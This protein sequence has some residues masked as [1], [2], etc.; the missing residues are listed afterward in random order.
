MEPDSQYYEVITRFL[1]NEASPEE[2]Q[3]VMEWMAT[4]EK[5]RLYV[6]ELKKALHLVSLAQDVANVDLDKEWKRLH[7][8]L[9]KEQS[10]VFQINH[11][12][13]ADDDYDSDEKQ[14]GRTRIFKFLI[15]VAV[16]ASLIFMIGLGAGWFSS[17]IIPVNE[18]AQQKKPEEV[19]AKIDPLMTVVQHEVNTSGK[20]KQLILPDGTKI[21][22]YNNSELT[23]KEPVA[24]KRRD[25][26]LLGKADFSVARN[27]TKPFTVFSED[28]STTA[29]GTVFTVDVSKTEKF[30]RIKLAEGKVVV[31]SLKGY[32]DK[33]TGNHYLVPGQELVYDKK[34][35][36]IVVNSFVLAKQ[37]RNKVVAQLK[38]NPSIPHYDKRSWFMFNNQALSEIFD[39][40]AEMYDVKIVY[41][42]KDVKDMYFIGTYDKSD[43]LHKILNQIALLNNLG[44]TRQNDTF[45]IKKQIP[46]K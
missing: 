16:A 42:K 40:L 22:L 2:E 23:Y 27:K 28:I 7:K 18:T 17:N 15:G 9:F 39:A 5:N 4:E 20:T 35:K 19:E 30:I 36:A 46:K 34:S 41:D 29:I 37:V 3:F 44:V 10:R 38:E 45:K 43:S 12:T 13:V 24:G 11:N 31:R 25:V 26:Y 6:E 21:A 8:V 1:L 32:N 14:N 33:W